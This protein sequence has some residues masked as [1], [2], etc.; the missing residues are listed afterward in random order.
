MGAIIARTIGYRRGMKH[1]FMV[2]VLIVGGCT[3]RDHE[4]VSSAPAETT[5]QVLP[6]AP[7]VDAAPATERGTTTLVVFDKSN[8]ATCLTASVEV[9]H[10]GRG[11]TPAQEASM[12]LNELAGAGGLKGDNA[13]VT[14][15]VS[16]IVDDTWNCSSPQG[17]DQIPC[18]EKAVISNIEVTRKRTP[19]ERKAAVDGLREWPPKPIADRVSKGEL[20]KV[21]ACP[22]RIALGTCTI[23][24]RSSAIRW[25]V[26]SMHYDVTSTSDSDSAMKTC[27]AAS[28]DWAAPS[29]DDMDANMERMRQH[30]SRATQAL[31]KLSQ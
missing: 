3:S 10:P 27:L 21:N 24:G 6:A 7:P 8:L 26:V 19:A 22:N 18:S 1:G 29:K 23:R 14:G 31:D 17:D 12:F 2:T 28:G 13:W 9:L 5:K 16:T 15:T 25:E 20:A 11:E 4:T 30:A